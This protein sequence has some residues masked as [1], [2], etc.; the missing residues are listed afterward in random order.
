MRQTPHATQRRYSKDGPVYVLGI[1]W[2]LLLDYKASAF[3]P[4]MIFWGSKKSDLC[5]WPRHQVFER[6]L[7]DHNS[8]DRI[9]TLVLISSQMARTRNQAAD[10]IK[11][12]APLW[13]SA[14][15]KSQMLQLRMMSASQWFRKPSLWCPGA[16]TDWAIT[17]PSNSS[18]SQQKQEDSIFS[19][20]KRPTR[21]HNFYQSSPIPV[22]ISCLWFI[23]IFPP[24]LS[25]K[26]QFIAS[27][28]HFI[29][30]RSPHCKPCDTLVMDV[31][32]SSKT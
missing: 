3:S 7:E 23:L 28:H 19:Y 13:T 2:L 12:D 8:F 14:K 10:S 30:C 17:S 1:S 20:S 32:S 27:L 4:L 22:H 24:L 31:D 15:H 29:F 6:P 5:V 26:T 11:E 18:F 16:L 21:S 25:H 9:S